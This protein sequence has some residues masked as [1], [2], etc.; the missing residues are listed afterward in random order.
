MRITWRG[1]NQAPTFGSHI[2]VPDFLPRQSYDLMTKILNW[3]P[4]DNVVYD[5]FALP[6]RNTGLNN[7]QGLAVSDCHVLYRDPTTHYLLHLPEYSLFIWLSSIEVC[8]KSQEGPVSSDPAQRQRQRQSSFIALP[9][10]MLRSSIHRKWA[11][12]GR[13][14]QHLNHSTQFSE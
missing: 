8:A 9:G 14:C 3:Q 6:A 7:K 10:S 1:C 12:W 4:G 11:V 5:G 2:W 13:F